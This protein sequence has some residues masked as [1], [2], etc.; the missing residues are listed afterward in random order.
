MSSS[1]QLRAGVIGLGWAGQQH[2]AAYADMTDVDLVA[3]AGMEADALQRLGDH[4]NVS[5]EHRYSNWQDLVDHAQVDLLS[6]A[7]PTTLHAPIAVAALDAGIHVLSEKPLAE[8]ADAARVM[9][10]A[11]ERNDRVLDVSFNHRQRGHIKVLKG[12]IDAGL[13]GR[14][15]YAKVGWLRREGIPGLGSWFTRRATAGGG[16]L[17]DLGVH[18]LDIALY[19]LDEPQVRA[20][21]AATYAEFGPRGKGSSASP[22]MHKTGMEPGV[23]DVEDLSTAFLRLK[24]GG[25][26]LLESSWAQWIPKDR[27]YV[28]MYGSDGGASIEWGAPDDP[29]RTLD[30]WTEKEG[31]PATLHP[32]IPPDGKHAESVQDFIAKVR[33]GDYSNHR[34]K[35]ALARAVV[36]DACYASAEKGGEIELNW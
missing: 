24:D 15:Y 28:T 11:A 17:M 6:I 31:M 20:V 1:D 13:L 16:P 34:G 30:I 7:A 10:E 36:I 32:N 21:T 12:I 35:Q 14:I 3:L 27:C 19:L 26:L 29:Q 4:Y 33:S 23:F 18:M 25:T 9:V 22:F 5:K 2:M 8:N